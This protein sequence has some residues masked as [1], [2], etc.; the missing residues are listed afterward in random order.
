MHEYENREFANRLIPLV[1]NLSYVV[2]TGEIREGLVTL[3]Q[4]VGRNKAI[5]GVL[6]SNP[7]VAISYEELHIV[8]YGPDGYDTYDSRG[9]DRL[10]VAINRVRTKLKASSDGLEQRLETVRDMGYR[11]TDPTL[12]KEE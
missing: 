8:C 2:E 11:W 7:N 9:K 10:K 6:V 12:T 3:E 5:F 1:D 4:F